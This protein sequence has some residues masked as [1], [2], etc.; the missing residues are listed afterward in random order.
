MGWATRCLRNLFCLGKEKECSN[1][2]E[3]K[4]R[5]DLD[6]S[7]NVGQIPARA[8]GMIPAATEASWPGNYLSETEK[9]QSEHAIAAA[10]ATATAADA[11]VAAAQAA[12]AVV[13]LTSHRRG[14]MFDADQDQRAAVKIQTAFRRYIVR[15]TA[16]PFDVLLLFN[17]HSC[18][19]ISQFFFFAM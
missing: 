19:V 10:A 3:E 8:K 6:G 13:R 15:I 18:M 9:E 2:S 12:V 16:S 14:T 5:W 1:S 4:E 7:C 11:A 17:G